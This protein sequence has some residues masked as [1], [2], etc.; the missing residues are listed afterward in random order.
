MNAAQQLCNA[1]HT[2]FTGNSPLV[3]A[4]TGGLSRDRAPEGTDKPYMVYSIITAPNEALYTGINRG[5]FDVQFTLIGEGHDTQG[6]NMATFLGV[7]DEAQFTLG[8]GVNFFQQRV[9]GP[10]SE[11]AAGPESGDKS[12]TISDLWQWMVT[13]RYS[14]Q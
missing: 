5:T 12:D 11:M 3:A 13:F 7:F 8:S 1:I 6:A 2:A 10:R 9:E 4:V 14:I